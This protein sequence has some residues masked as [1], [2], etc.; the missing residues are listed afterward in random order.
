MLRIQRGDRSFPTTL[1]GPARLIALFHWR[2]GQAL[3]GM[4][5][6]ENGAE[7]PGPAPGEVDW[8]LFPTSETQAEMLAHEARF[9]RHLVQRTVQT[10]Q[11]G[12]PRR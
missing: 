2:R 12:A 11:N 4:W 6:V 3:P 7:H 9:A 8:S 5:V 10:A 1:T